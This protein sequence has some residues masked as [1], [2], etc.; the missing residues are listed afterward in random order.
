MK[1]PIALTVAVLAV[2]QDA[3]TP[4]SKRFDWQEKLEILSHMEIVYADDGSG[5]TYGPPGTPGK[6]VK[7]LRISGVNVQIVNGAGKTYSANGHGNL[8]LGY[9]E[10]VGTRKRT[11]SHTLVIGPDHS[12][13][14]SGNLLVGDNH[15]ALAEDPASSIP[16]NGVALVGGSWNMAMGHGTV[17]GGSHS[18]VGA[19]YGTVAGGRSNGIVAGGDYATVTGGA[20]TFLGDPYDWQ[21]V[22]LP[23]SDTYP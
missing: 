3:L 11:G 4:F 22:G 8:I 18:M 23:E 10:G 1:T 13:L 6:L 16:S 15:F 12:W 9:D 2:G 5:L 19:P 21:A 20:A 17:L 14:G 7:T